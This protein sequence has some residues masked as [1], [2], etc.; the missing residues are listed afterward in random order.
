MRSFILFAAIMSIALLFLVNSALALKGLEAQTSG[1]ASTELTPDTTL[2]RTVPHDRPEERLFSWMENSRSS[3]RP[4]LTKMSDWLKRMF[5]AFLALFKSPTAMNE[6]MKLDAAEPPFVT[7]GDR[8]IDISK[9][10][11]DDA[12]ANAH[13]QEGGVKRIVGQDKVAPSSILLDGVDMDEAG[14]VKYLHEQYPAVIKQVEGALAEAIINKS[15]QDR[16]GWMGEKEAAQEIFKLPKQSEDSDYMS[17]ILLTTWVLKKRDRE[18]VLNTLKL[19]ND[20]VDW[21][22]QFLIASLETLAKL[23]PEQYA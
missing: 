22:K 19:D 13:K 7:P 9:A 1:A 21:Y 11:K 2:L 20:I 23:K 17:E 6:A 8:P 16:F 15:Y 5:D 12:G 3:G 18:Y 4:M 14:M 10:V